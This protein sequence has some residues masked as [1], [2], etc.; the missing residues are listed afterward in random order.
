MTKTN[1][2]DSVVGYVGH[3]ARGLFR[4]LC[5]CCN[6]QFPLTD[7]AQIYGDL[8]VASG[9]RD[10]MR[11]DEGCGACGATFAAL[12]ERCQSEYEAQQREFARS[13]VT[14]VVEMGMVGAVRCRVY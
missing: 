3:N 5:V 4:A 13:P 11:V 14:H 2:K 9:P 12:S 6:D 8:Y 1:A 7:T 10:R